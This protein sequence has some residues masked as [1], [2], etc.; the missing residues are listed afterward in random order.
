MKQE[1]F[2]VSKRL[3]SFV[4]AFNGLRIMFREEHNS[5]IHLLAAVIAIVLGWCLHISYQEWITIILVIG[6]VFF[7][8]LFNSSL[9]QLC[10]HLSPEKHENI[11]KVK[12]LAAAA[13]LVS[14]LT[15]L[16][17]GG[18]IFLPKIFRWMNW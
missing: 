7:A 9:E 13:V 17:I 6:F 14:A 4:H 15:S 8:E 18:V 2:S 10:D 11:R 3:K 12:D 1:K 16:I 5:R